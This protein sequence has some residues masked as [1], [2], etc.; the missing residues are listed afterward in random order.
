MAST[1]MSLGKHWEDFIKKQVG[2]GNYA[3]SSEVMREAL[4]RWEFEEAQIE[5]LRSLID[6]GER[7]GYIED[8]NPE[9]FKARMRKK[10]PASLHEDEEAFKHET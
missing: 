1:S 2:S 3:S 5:N 9:E 6:E 8:W 7:S 4:R 10:Y